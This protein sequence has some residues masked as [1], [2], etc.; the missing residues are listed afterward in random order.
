MQCGATLVS[1]SSSSLSGTMSISFWPAWITPPTVCTAR[2]TTWPVGGRLDVDA[3]Q[4]V[5]QRA[6]LAFVRLDFA[7]SPRLSWVST[8]L[9]YSCCREIIL[10]RSSPIGALAPGS[11]LPSSS[12]M[13]AFASATMRSSSSCRLRGA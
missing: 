1:I 10:W 3:A 7:A 13:D 2:P 12:A 9:R 8:S 6:E 4:V 11:M 5:R